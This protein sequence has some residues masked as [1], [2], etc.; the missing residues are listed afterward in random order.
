VRNQSSTLLAE[1]RYNGLNQR[2]TWHYDAD[3]DADVDGS[4]PTYHF[5][6]DEKWRMV[7]TWRGTDS[8]PKELFVN[9]QAG[10]AGM[11]GSS[12][13]DTVVLRDKDSTNGWTGTPDGTS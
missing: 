5:A 9:H 10:L 11:G 1:Y 12:Y 2:I 6:Y 4:D 13:I 3:N 7:G 8:E